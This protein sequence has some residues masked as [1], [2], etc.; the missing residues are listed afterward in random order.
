MFKRIATMMIVGLTL[1]ACASF[2]NVLGLTLEAYSPTNGAIDVPV[3]AP[4]WARF[5]QDV[6]ELTLDGEFTLAVQGGAAVAG[7]VDYDDVT[8]TATFKPTDELAYATVYVASVSGGIATSGGASL[9]GAVSWTFTTEDAP[10]VEPVMA[11]LALTVNGTGSVQVDGND[12]ADGDTFEVGSDVTFVAVPGS[13]QEVSE[14]GG[15]CAAV[16]VG[17][18][19]TLTITG[20][21]FTVEVTFA[22]QV[23]VL[24]VT[25]TG[26]GS[27]QVADADVADGDEFDVGSDVTF[28]AVAASGFEFSA[29]GG[30]CASTVGASCTVTVVGSSLDVSVTFTPLPV[31]FVSVTSNSNAETNSLSVLVPAGSTVGDFLVAHIAIRD[32]ATIGATPAGWTL[33]GAIVVTPSGDGGMSQAI[34]YR[35]ASASEPASYAWTFSGNTR[36]SGAIMRFQNVDLSNPVAASGSSLGFTDVANAPS[37]A[38]SANSMV[39]ALFGTSRNFSSLTQPAGMDVQYTR[40]HSEPSGPRIRGATLAFSSAASSPAR[41]AQL[42]ESRRWVGHSIVLR[43]Y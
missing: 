23:A 7:D 31:V 4:V 8:F 39:L 33:L 34:Y 21:T 29:W 41:T 1:A 15:A 20:P 32:A 19:C 9:S 10:D 14:W 38:A 18:E 22:Q 25:V 30:D 42:A 27:V 2:P 35:A 17:D 40:V 26:S 36:A 5:N 6:S 11:T 16:A 37:V 3:T 43:G 24:D 13:N 28:V 12:V